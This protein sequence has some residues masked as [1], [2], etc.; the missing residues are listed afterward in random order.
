MD[1]EQVE[2]WLKEAFRRGDVSAALEN[3]YPRYAWV[4]IDDTCFEGRLSNSG[5]GVYKG[6]PLS[7]D[8]W[9]AWLS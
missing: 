5:Q 9:P 8:Q 4:R 7:E 2:G 1:F 6:Y 3:G